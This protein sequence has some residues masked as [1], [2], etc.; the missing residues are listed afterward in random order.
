MVLDGLAILEY[1]H[2]FYLII[3][4]KFLVMGMLLIK[5]FIIKK[6][7]NIICNSLKIIFPKRLIDYVSIFLHEFFIGIILITV[8]AVS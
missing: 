7:R 2:N 5:L 1:L 4:S 3:S 8:S 6:V